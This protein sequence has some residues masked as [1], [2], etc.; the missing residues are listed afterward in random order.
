MP[1]SFVPGC[2]CSAESW[3]VLSLSL[4][5][6]KHL[7]YRAGFLTSQLTLGLD[8]FILRFYF[9][10]FREGEEAQMERENLK[11]AST[12]SAEAGSGL[13]VKTPGS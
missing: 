9:L 4:I 7:S 2:H 12:P 10:F 5:C 11:Q 8:D 6:H 1:V 13:N 3:C